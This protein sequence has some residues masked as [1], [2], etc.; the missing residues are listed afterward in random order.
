M[1][2]SLALPA[3]AALA[4]FYTDPDNGNKLLIPAGW[5]TEEKDDPLVKIKFVPSS[6]SSPVM[7]YGSIDLWNTLSA[8]AQK[9]IPRA[10]FNNDQFS[11][12]DIADLVGAKTK[13]V[14]MV[15]LGSREYFRAEV[16]KETTIGQYKFSMTATYWLIAEDG[17]LY[18]YQFGGDR[19]HTLYKRFETM[20]SRATYGG[21]DFDSILSGNDSEIYNSAVEAY[22]SG[23]YAKANQLFVS[24]DPYHDSGKYLRLIRI[25]NAGS[26]IG[27]GSE[28]YVKECGLTDS[29]K[30]DIDVA[31]KDFYFADTA[32]VLLCNSDVASYY[33]VGKW[34]GGSKCYIHFKMNNYGGTYN[35]GS[36][37]STNYKST[38]S[39]ND[40]EL[41]VDVNKTN[42]LTL[43][44]TLTAPDCM[45][46]LTY[47]K[48][49]K[50]YT[51]KRK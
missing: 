7:Q 9:K 18:L 41:H 48:N 20:V 11:K 5:K 39:I 16:T 4:S 32:E 37:L 26:N 28:V 8:S 27:V 29:D 17:W 35:I 13:Q 49:C 47:E 15:V 34:N 40:G 46:V 50:T 2:L 12:S 31:A 19:N 42:K 43:H 38:F 1:V 14:E 36:K 10:E 24:V 45:E 44:L 30:K 23:D 33:L 22:E 3:N 21:A 25:R 51:L 6:G